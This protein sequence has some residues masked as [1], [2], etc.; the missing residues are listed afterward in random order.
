DDRDAAEWNTAALGP[1]KRARATDLLWRLKDTIA[2]QGLVHVG[3]G[4]WYPAEPLPRW[5]LG[6]YWR[7]DG[8][9]IWRNTALC[10]DESH[11]DGAGPEDAERFVRELALRLDVPDEFVRAGYEDVWYY[12]WRERRLPVNV[13]PF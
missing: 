13:D 11:P 6:C 8:E 3:Q 2:P 12:L 4:K 9:P 1:T 5:A 7:A 10:A